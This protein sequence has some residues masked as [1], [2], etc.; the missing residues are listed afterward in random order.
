MQ[1]LGNIMLNFVRI[2]D[3]IINWD[4]CRNGSWEW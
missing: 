3:K 4:N 2:R 1:E